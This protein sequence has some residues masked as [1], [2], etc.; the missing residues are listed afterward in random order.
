MFPGYT[1]VVVFNEYTGLYYQGHLILLLQI[2]QLAPP[3][4]RPLNW[5]YTLSPNTRI[6]MLN[7]AI[8]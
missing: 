7:Y 8:F 5:I 6:H 2:R 1:H 3:G 4:D